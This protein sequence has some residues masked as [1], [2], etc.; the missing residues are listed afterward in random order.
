M[1]LKVGDERIKVSRI[2]LKKA[3]RTVNWLG[4]LTAGVC[5]GT[6]LWL[7]Y[8]IVELYAIRLWYG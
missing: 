3:E 2:S 7:W 4:W 5:V 8:K 1:K 6:I